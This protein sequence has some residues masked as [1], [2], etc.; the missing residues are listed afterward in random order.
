MFDPRIGKY[1]ND[2]SRTVARMSNFEPL[3]YT[4]K[5]RVRD[6]LDKLKIGEQTTGT[7]HPFRYL[8]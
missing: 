2:V 8:A 3:T 6:Q 5:V 7:V 1:V 4:G